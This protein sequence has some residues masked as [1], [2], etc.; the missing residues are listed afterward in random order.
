[1]HW[2]VY[3]VPSYGNEWYWHN[4]CSCPNHRG[5]GGC[6]L[7]SDVEAASQSTA[8]AKAASVLVGKESLCDFHDRVYGP[9]FSYS[10]FTPMFKAELFDTGHLMDVFK[11]SG[12]KY[13]V[14]TSKHHDGFCLWPCPGSWAWNSVDDGPHRDLI[15]EISA[16]VHNLSSDIHIAV[17]F[18]TFDWFNPLY[19]ADK[20]NGGNTTRYVDEVGRVV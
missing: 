16:A 18:S 13:L 8:G 14:P 1:M 2:G 12:A 3:S 6:P 4:L 15:G 19:L 9:S 7:Q 5:K 11:K 17:Y 20:A 10:D